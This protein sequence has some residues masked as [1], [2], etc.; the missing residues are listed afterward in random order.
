[1]AK[2][3]TQENT[4]RTSDGGMKT[5]KYSRA[6]AIKLMCMECMG[7]ETHPKDCTSKHCPL[8]PFRGYTQT[9]LK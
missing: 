2:A 1:M 7:W 3:L 4:I 9:G 5:I 6:M 8:F